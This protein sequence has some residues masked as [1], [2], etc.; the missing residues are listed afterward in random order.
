[1]ELEKSIWN[2]LSPEGRLK[3]QWSKA[4][5]ETDPDM[6]LNG[7]RVVLHS[8]L[9]TPSAFIHLWISFWIHFLI[10]ILLAD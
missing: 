10:P 4:L 3:N 1:M 5:A 7:L 9:D 2:I 6:R 8:L